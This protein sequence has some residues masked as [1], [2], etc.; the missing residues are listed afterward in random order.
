[1]VCN[2]G[3]IEDEYHVMFDCQ[4]H[5]E[6]RNTLINKAIGVMPEFPKLNATHKIKVLTSNIHV[7]LIRKTT[8]Y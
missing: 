4:A 3:N 5:K 2:E 6:A 1:M 8:Y 7:N